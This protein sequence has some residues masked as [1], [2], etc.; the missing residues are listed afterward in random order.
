MG[1]LTTCLEFRVP[2]FEFR[3]L[4]T[5]NPKLETALRLPEEGSP[6]EDQT[7]SDF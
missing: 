6:L 4:T 1:Q 2:G 3:A 5:R 7:T